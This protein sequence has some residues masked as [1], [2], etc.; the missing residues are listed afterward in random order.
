MMKR[1]NYFG[2]FGI[3][4]IILTCFS[5]QAFSQNLSTVKLDASLYDYNVISIDSRSMKQTS[6]SNH[7]FEV[8]IPRPQGNNPWKVELHNSGIIGDNYL[9]Q[10]LTEDGTVTEYGAKA[11]PTKGIVVG[12]PNTSVRLT[13]N[14]GFV[15]G[16]INDKSGYHFIEP[17]SYYDKNQSGKDLYVIYHESDIKPEAS[18]SCGADHFHPNHDY[19]PEPYMERGSDDSRNND[20]YEVDIAIANDYT[21]FEE[22][23]SIVATEDHAI[24]V[25]NNV[26]GNYD[27]EF[28]D[29]LQYII[30]TQFTV[31]TSGGDPWSSSADT[32]ILLPSFRSWG[33]GGGFG[34]VYDVASLWTDKN[35]FNDNGSGVVGVAY[36]SAICTNNRYNLLENFTSN[37]NTK[38]MM[39]AHELGHNF[40]SNHDPGGSNTIMAP[41]VNTA[42]TWSQQSIN[43]I[44]NHVATRWCLSDCTGSS[45]PP[46][47]SFTFEVFEDCTPGL[48]QFTNTSTGS[49]SLTYEWEFQGGNPSFSTEEN[50]L[51]SYNFAGSYD[52]TL[53]VTNTS[54]S[55]E[56]FQNNVIDIIA[57]PEPDFSYAINGTVVS[58]FNIS[59]N[60][61]AYFWDFG[62]GTTS[63]SS[64]PVHDFFNDGVYNVQLTA[65]SICG[66]VT[67]EEII[68]IANPPT[69]GFDVDV[70]EGCAELVVQYT[71]T[72][73]NNTDDWVWTFEGGTPAT[74]SEENPQVT[75]TEAGEFDVTLTV[76]N[77][78]GDDIISF[79]DFILVKDIPFADFSFEVDES[80]VTFTNFS[81]GADSYLWDFGDGNSSTEENPVHT[82]ASD[83]DY[84]VILTTTNECGEHTFSSTVSISLVPMASFITMQEA[85]DCA[86][87][88]LDFESTSTN[89]P[90]TYLWTFEGGD[91]AMSTDANPSVT[92]SDAGSFDVTLTVSNANGSDTMT[93]PDYVIVNDEPISAYTFSE[94]GLTVTF[95]DGSIDGD[96]YEWDFG[97]GNSSDEVNP[98]HT[99]ANEGI[100]EVSLTVFNECGSN[101]NTQLIN[102]YTPVTANFSSDITAGCANLTVQFGDESSPN[103]TNWLWTFEGGTPA[104]STEENPTVSYDAAGQYDVILTVSHPESSET[105]TLTNY[106]AVSDVPIT[107]F[108][109]FDD[110][111]EV[112][113]TNTTVEGTTY[114]WD[115]GDGNTSTEESPSH[116][117]AD[118]GEY[119]VVLTATNECGSTASSETL[120]VNAL[121]TAG[122]DSETQSGC[123]PLSVQFNDASSSNVIAWSW[124]FEGGNPATSTDPNPLVEYASAGSYNV[125]LVVTSAAGTDEIILND[126]I[127]VIAGPTAEI[128]YDLVGNVINATNNGT[129]AT[130]TTWTVDG[131][132]INEDALNYTFPEN[133]TYT[134]TLTTENACGTSTESID[135]MIDV[136]P[137]ALYDGFPISVCVGEEIQLMDNSTNAEEKLWTLDGANPATSTEDS[138]MVVYETEGV[139]SITLK[140]SNQY[141]ESTQ[142]F[143]D[144]VNVIGLPTAEFTGAQADNM[145]EFT[146]EGTNVS[147][148]FWDFGD[149]NTSTEQNPTH[150]FTT[151]GMFEVKL[152]VTNECGEYFVTETYTIISNSVSEEELASVNIYPNP[153]QT[154]LNI[155]LTNREGDIINLDVIDINGKLVLSTSFNTAKYV[156][157]VNDI[158]AGTYLIRL[159]SEK[160]A[161][162]KKVVILK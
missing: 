22:F 133:G 137:T 140:V 37:P 47:A 76:V 28:A 156:L 86:T 57:S 110:I 52:V 148:Y 103:V 160:A 111:L 109:Y 80:E 11:I 60:A 71:S 51:V 77:E 44:N 50:P 43:S 92:Y 66:D 32:G 21:M 114:L 146:A 42:T 65:S 73:S 112:D 40:S 95:V 108:E 15:Y 23:G 117:Y 38:R 5:A 56:E 118:E 121:P 26:Q 14:D 16:Y 90:D 89:N 127:E 53:T 55:D 61:T 104:T 106:I 150:T 97:D 135:V 45:G 107:S 3:I 134:V 161:Y 12:K 159:R 119:E 63:T 62:D 154:D 46:S 59:Q 141:G 39:V 99:Y 78:T 147:T 33:N 13:F 18:H 85:E 87:F 8:D 145:V 29:E 158:T 20:C 25:M 91:P 151:N 116:T 10:A 48:V 88:V 27:D 67:T 144:V 82:Y 64:D 68:V 123:G 6:R 58:F 125:Q 79:T 101:T 131:N 130:T 19:Q 113:F 24:G 17:L 93:M 84:N 2:L 4:M 36:L 142:S 74:S 120:T 30:V 155:D 128:D 54:G 49:G 157:D 81:T 126:Y 105:I 35:I 100:Y 143:I 98:V 138:P 152:T 102:N 41:V 115:F 132:D 31:S 149:G 75:Y 129:G 1:F 69:A 162:Y 153:A 70:Q 7:F 96:T 83:G 136:Y 94:D 72:A 124:T 34:A 9:S 122:I 139:Y